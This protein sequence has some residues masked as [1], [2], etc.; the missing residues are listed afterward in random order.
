MPD[1]VRILAATSTRQ[2]QAE[3]SLSTAELN[4]RVFAFRQQLH[5]PRSDPRAQARELYQH[6]FAPLARNLESENVRRLVLIEDG[7]LRYLPFAALFDGERYLI[8]RY[9]VVVA[10]PAIRTAAGSTTPVEDRV[11]AFGVTKSAP[12]FGPLPR[13]ATEL[14][15]IVRRDA[16]DRLGVLPGIVAL[17]EDFTAARFR[18]ALVAGFPAIHI[19]SHFLF[20]PGVVGESYLLLGGGQH[21]TLDELR[22]VQYP[23]RNVQ[24]LTLSACET[25]VG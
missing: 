16:N 4:K 5:S 20:R 9:E 25:A 17:D 3:A 12:G 19:A 22:S 23:L 11:A 13:V 15:R 1:R 21:L 24:L 6:L 10:T 14:D 7:T 8:E 2:W 18:A